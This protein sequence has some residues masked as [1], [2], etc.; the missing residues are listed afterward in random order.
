MIHPFTAHPI[1]VDIEGGSSMEVSKY[2]AQTC[3]RK[4]IAS[5]VLGPHSS[6]K[7]VKKSKSLANYE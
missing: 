1:C 3:C 4:F 5:K 7:R 2:N 6:V